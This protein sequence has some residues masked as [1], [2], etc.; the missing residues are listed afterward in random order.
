MPKAQ[1]GFSKEAVKL[2]FTKVL[3]KIKA[4]VADRYK[5]PVYI[6]NGEMPTVP[7]EFNKLYLCGYLWGIFTEKWEEKKFLFFFKYRYPMRTRL[8]DASTDP[9]NY[10]MKKIFCTIYDRELYD[11]TKKAV[12]EFSE[13]YNVEV[14]IIKEFID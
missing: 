6:E 13:K 10:D 4:E 7:P 3:E 2:G 5:D 1:E 12:A 9:T 11:I 8:I 14:T